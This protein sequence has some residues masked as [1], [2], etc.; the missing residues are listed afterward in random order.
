MRYVRYF[1]ILKDSSLNFSTDNFL[2][3]AA[4]CTTIVHM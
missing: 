4:I 3:I 2:A 1:L